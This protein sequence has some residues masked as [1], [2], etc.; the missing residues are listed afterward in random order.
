MKRPGPQTT[1]PRRAL[2]LSRAQ[3]VTRSGSEIVGKRIHGD[4]NIKADNVTIRDCEII[5]GNYCVND[6]FRAK[7]TIIEHCR[8]LQARSA[9][10]I[11]NDAKISNCEFS[12]MGADAIKPAWNVEIINNWIHSIGSRRGSHADGIQMTQGKRVKIIGNFIDCSQPPPLGYLNSSCLMIQTNDGPIEDIEIENNW[13]FGGAYAV[14]INGKKRGHGPPTGVRLVN[15]VFDRSSIYGPWTF[16][17]G[18]SGA[19]YSEFNNRFT[20]GEWVGNYYPAEMAESPPVIGLE[21]DTP[22]DEPLPESPK[23]I[24]TSTSVKIDNVETQI[25]G[26]QSVTLVIKLKIQ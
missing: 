12:D 19:T 4:L 6:T 17:G 5:G 9:G 25:D 21:I 2:D 22:I 16:G 7:G 14:N 15:N 10:Y 11:G 26:P 13:L 23:G 20:D 1:G 18:H 3:D 8:M 24:G